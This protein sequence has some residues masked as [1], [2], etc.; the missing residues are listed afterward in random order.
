MEKVRNLLIPERFY[1]LRND[2]KLIFLAGPIDSAPEWQDQAVAYLTR[3]APHIYIANPRGAGTFE[4]QIAPGGKFSRRKREW[5]SDLIDRAAIGPG[6]VLFWLPK[7]AAHN[8]N[9]PYGS[10]TRVELGEMI[11]MHQAR[12]DFN[13]CVG[14]DET[15]PD[16]SPI[17]YDL[18]KKCN[19]MPLESLEK[20]CDEAISLANIVNTSMLT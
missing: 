9:H 4:D 7:P 8:C 20:T 18:K 3:K 14:A 19:M 12:P 1:E 5:E 17:L 15:F 11:G 13:F 10:M 6:C 2:D 16:L